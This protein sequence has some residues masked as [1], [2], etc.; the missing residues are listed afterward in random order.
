M[1]KEVIS[2]S[3]IS[4][5]IKMIPD[6]R[7]K[8]KGK[9]LYLQNKLVKKLL[10]GKNPSIEIGGYNVFLGNKYWGYVSVILIRESTHPIY[11]QP[12]K[13]KKEGIFL[14]IA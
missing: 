2:V 1:K 13:A 6:F 10:K 4:E 7:K 14:K 8:A 12:K 9:N 3:T 11:M 5:F